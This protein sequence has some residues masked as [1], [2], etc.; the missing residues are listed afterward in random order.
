MRSEQIQFRDLLLRLRQGESRVDDWKL[1]LTRQP[2][3]VTN[4]C[5]FDEATRLFC[6]NEQVANYNNEQLT[7]LE[8]PVARKQPTSF[9]T[10]YQEQFNLN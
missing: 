3:N 5:D 8:H 4:L 6:S 9:S 1:L 10:D 7:K 2:S